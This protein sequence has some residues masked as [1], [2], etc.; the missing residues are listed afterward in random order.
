M[1]LSQQYDLSLHIAHRAVINGT[2]I[3]LE[4]ES[5]ASLSAFLQF[6]FLTQTSFWHFFVLM[7]E[8]H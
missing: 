3:N 4:R 8:Q 5:S 6:F 7:E 2:I 1:C